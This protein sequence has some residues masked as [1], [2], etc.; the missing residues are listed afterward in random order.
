MSRL[1][2]SIPKEVQ[3]AQ[4][5]VNGMVS[6]DERL[7]LGSGVSVETLTA[8]VTA[9]TNA[10]SEYNTMLAQVDEKSNEIEALIERMNDLA[11]RSLKGAEFKF[12]CDSNEFE[13]IGGTRKSDRKRPIRK[14]GG[15]TETV[16]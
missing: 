9:V 15:G 5:R 3:T 7:D 8:S 14:N 13:M 16:K 1:R 4:Q 10:I 2:K 11:T 6:V 12:G